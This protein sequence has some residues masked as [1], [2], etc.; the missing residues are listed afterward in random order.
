MRKYF[1]IKKLGLLIV[2]GI[3][4]SAF[5][6]WY[7]NNLV[8]RK[9]DGKTFSSIEEIPFNKTGLLL[10]TGMLLGNGNVNPFFQNRIAATV[11]LMK[12]GKIENLIIS[13]D[14]GRVGYD[15]PS[16]MRNQLIAAGI[17]STRIYLDYAGFRTYDSMVRAKKIFGQTNITV[18]S[19]LFHNE[20]AIY[21]AESFGMNAIGYNAADVEGERG[22]AVLIREKLARVNAW[23]DVLVSKDPHF[24]GPQVTILP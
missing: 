17:D 7:C 15:E 1:T 6:L 9:S 3:G 5:L 11:Q 23:L 16:D 21:I 24:L 13:G 14:N 4:I 8:L 20:R 22:E 18:I 12:A 19:Q 10:G 2:L